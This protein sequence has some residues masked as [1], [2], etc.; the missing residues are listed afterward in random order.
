[1]MG[2]Q[3]M[4][5][6]P[7]AIKGPA[8]KR[9]V[10]DAIVLAFS[11]S[12]VRDVVGTD[13]LRMVLEGHYRDMM[14]TPG[15]LSLQPV[16]D[17]LLK[18][19]GVQAD[20]ATP[21]FCRI[22]QW[23]G[24]LNIPIE[25]PQELGELTTIER[26]RHAQKCKVPDEELA[27]ILNPNAAPAPKAKE[28]VPVAT[29]PQLSSGITAQDAT[30]PLRRTI[31]YVLFAVGIIAATG[32]IWWAVGGAKI[33]NI[34][35]AQISTDIPLKLAKRSGDTIG[36]VLSDK[37]AWM[38]RSQPERMRLLTQALEKSQALGAERFVLMDE[39]GQVFGHAQIG[40]D[41]KPNATVQ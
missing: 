7:A 37:S 27:R 5:D 31:A 24:R 23:E 6:T 18:Q 13:A 12:D 35:P 28:A 4:A 34:T 40:E 26:D 25:M 2:G 17:L 20:Q 3:A 36:A 9:T 22:K 30:S 8:S 19:P 29:A 39:Q 14:K 38:A 41:G 11:K 1:M 32:S 21:A 15:V 33:E 16:Y 10:V